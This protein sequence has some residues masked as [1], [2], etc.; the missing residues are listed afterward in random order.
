MMISR[1][2]PTTTMQTAMTVAVSVPE[3]ASVDTMPVGGGERLRQKGGQR[4]GERRGGRL[5][6]TKKR[7][8]RG[9]GEERQGEEGGE[10]GWMKERERGRM[11]SKEGGGRD[12]EGG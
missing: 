9:R 12:G 4:R 5:R 8:W 10:G 3:L 7:G 6:D 1:D 11:D 2:M